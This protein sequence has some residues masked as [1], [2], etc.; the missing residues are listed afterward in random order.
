M[1]ACTHTKTKQ[2]YSGTKKTII[3]VLATVTSVEAILV[4]ALNSVRSCSV[5]LSPLILGALWVLFFH[6]RLLGQ[7]VFHQQLILNTINL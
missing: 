6:M 3:T 1:H 5:P 7:V 4:N 2:I